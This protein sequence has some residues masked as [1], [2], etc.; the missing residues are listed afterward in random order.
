MYINNAVQRSRSTQDGSYIVAYGRVHTFLD[1]YRLFD[2]ECSIL[3]TLT[4][5]A[6][7]VHDTRESCLP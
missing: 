1:S 5:F 7:L 6:F 4:H 3:L 2:A